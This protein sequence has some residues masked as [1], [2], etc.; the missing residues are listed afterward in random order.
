MRLLRAHLAEA[1]TSSDAA[2]V[3]DRLLCLADAYRE[4]ARDNHNA[5]AAVFD[6]RTIEAPPAIAADIAAL[7]AVIENVLAALPGLDRNTIPVVAKAL[8]SSVHG[9][10]YLG[11]VGG[12][13]PVRREDLPAMIDTL[14]R[15]AVRGIEA[16]RK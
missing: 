13:G 4:F 5:W 12:L 11:E 3:D 6:K 1:L 10:V 15:A 16:G 14:V 2:A 9:M 8:W 7:F